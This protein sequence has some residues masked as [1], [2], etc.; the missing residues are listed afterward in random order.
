MNLQQHGFRAKR[1]IITAIAIA[2]EKVAA[3]KGNNS[4]GDLVLR[5]VEKEFDK[6]CMDLYIK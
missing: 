1:S 6:V 3:A 5:V 2:T 4:Y